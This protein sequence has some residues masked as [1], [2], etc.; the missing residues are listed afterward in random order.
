MTPG[1]LLARLRDPSDGAPAARLAAV[2]VDEALARPLGAL[3]RPGLLVAAAR[4]VMA[5]L[6]A[7]EG[8][9]AR[10]LAELELA[11]AALG[12]LGGPVGGLV[13]AP[14]RRALRALA[15]LPLVARRGAVLQLLDRPTLRQLLR[16]Q[17]VHTL[18]DFGR[19]VASPV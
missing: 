16:A 4:D 5:A 9:S 11:R 14:A 15:S 12:S 18:S 19:K 7:S 17:I 10:A 8:A 3:V 2:L 13:P 1:D 6:A